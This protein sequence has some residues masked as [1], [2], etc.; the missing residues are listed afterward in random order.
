MLRVLFG[1]KPLNCLDDADPVQGFYYRA[2][3]GEKARTF[4]AATGRGRVAAT[5]QPLGVPQVPEVRWRRRR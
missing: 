3:T 4:H 5:K 2:L 1:S